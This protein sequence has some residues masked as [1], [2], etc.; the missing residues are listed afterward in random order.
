MMTPQISGK[1]QF[2][3]DLK[4][5]RLPVTFTVPDIPD[6]PASEDHFDPGSNASTTDKETSFNETSNI[7]TQCT[8]TE[9]DPLDSIQIGVDQPNLLPAVSGHLF[10][11]CTTGQTAEGRVWVLQFTTKQSVERG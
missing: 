1:Y 7:H 5:L 2:Q 3:V 6:T 4:G 9:T 11:A 8:H 10:Y